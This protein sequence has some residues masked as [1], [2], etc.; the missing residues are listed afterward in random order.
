MKS[1]I[2]PYD[3][4]KTFYLTV[5]FFLIIF[6]GCATKD[7]VRN[8]SEDEVLRERVMTYWG[9]KISQ[10]FDK[11]YTYEDPYY[12]KRFNMIKYIKSIDTARASWKSATIEGLKIDGD[13]A[14]IDMKV[15][16]HITVAPSA[17]DIEQEF[18]L[19]ETWVKVD[20]IWYHVPKKSG[21]P[22]VT[23]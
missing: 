21:R 14:I 7:A 1:R 15:K 12:R 10:E 20:G 18:P 22:E 19:K 3:K 6:S 9:H 11:S 2:K 17:R 4:G 8:I 13:S 5:I 23:N 16:V